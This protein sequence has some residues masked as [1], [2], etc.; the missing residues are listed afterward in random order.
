[1]TLKI[2][3]LHDHQSPTGRRD[4]RS[5]YDRQPGN[6]Q[7]AF[8]FHWEAL[9][10]R[11]KE[12][13]V[14]DAAAKL[15]PE[16]KNGFRDFYEFRFFEGQLQQRPIGFFGPVPGVFTLLIWA[17]EKGN[18]FI[19]VEALATCEKR[20]NSILSGASQSVPW[21]ENEENDAHDPEKIIQIPPAWVSKRLR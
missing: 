4:V 11:L 1:M 17:T 14:R 21:D 6:V 5:Y 15:T 13:W 19:P 18:Q 2:W 3:R 8:D 10:V 12:R 7:A 16:K 9:E 20:M